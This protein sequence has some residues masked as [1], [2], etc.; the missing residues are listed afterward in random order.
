MWPQ[1]RRKVIHR[2]L[3]RWGLA[4]SRGVA[5]VR[6]PRKEAGGGS[7]PAPDVN[8]LQARPLGKGLMAPNTLWFCLYSASSI[9]HLS[10]RCQVTS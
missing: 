9:A 1:T 2:L 7:R 8:A 5:A 6:V 3:P 10:P 4:G